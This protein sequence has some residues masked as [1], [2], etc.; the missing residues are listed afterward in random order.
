MAVRPLGPAGT[1]TVNYRLTSADGHVVNGSWSFA[2]RRG[3][4]RH[5]GP[6][7]VP[8]PRPL[9]PV[10]AFPSGRSWWR[11]PRS[12]AQACGGRCGAGRD[13]SGDRRRSRG[14]HR[15][16]VV[17][18]ASVLAWALAQPSN[19]LA[20]STVR[21]LA[22]SAAVVTLGLTVVPM[23]DVGRHRDEL[24]RSSATPLGVTAAV[25][26]LAEVVRLIVVTAQ[27]RRYR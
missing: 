24:V 12:S 22:D 19:S 6:R 9:R 2:A 14:G 23:L 18:A 16:L 26:L 17:V 15:C 25:W 20:A 7:G 8:P 4:H 11:R 5:T 21:A 10:A 3:R 1:Y 13:R 27:A